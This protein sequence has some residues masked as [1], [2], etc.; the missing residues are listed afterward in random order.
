MSVNLHCYCCLRPMGS[1]FGAFELFLMG[2]AY[3]PFNHFQWSFMYGKC[4]GC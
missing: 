4:S 1:M 2:L 3:Q